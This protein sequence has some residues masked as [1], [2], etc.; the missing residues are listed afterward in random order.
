[1]TSVVD[2]EERDARRMIPCGAEGAPEARRSGGAAGPSDRSSG[3]TDFDPWLSHHLGRLYDP[4][5]V[6]PIPPQLLRMLEM[7]LK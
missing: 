1:M 7:R 4:I 5:I 6:E 3:K 2:N